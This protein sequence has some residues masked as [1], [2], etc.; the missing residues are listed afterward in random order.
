MG[1]IVNCTCTGHHNPDFGDL[2]DISAGHIAL[3]PKAVLGGSL[4]RSAYNR[5]PGLVPPIVGTNV[6]MGLGLS[7]HSRTYIVIDP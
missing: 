2:S 7:S 1:S 3:K 4:S 6:R 5:K